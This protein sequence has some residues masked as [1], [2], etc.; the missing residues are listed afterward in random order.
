MTRTLASGAALAAA[1]ALV[2]AGCGGDSEPDVSA[3]TQWAGDLCAAVDT[4]QSSIASI[5]S[6]L[7]SDPTKDGLESA[8]SDAQDATETLID[9]VKGLGS[10]DTESGDQAKSTVESLADSLQTNVDTIEN[11]VEDV[12]GVQGL[13]TAVSTVSAAVA[14]MTSEL[15]SSV[16][17]LQ[18]LGNVDNELQQSFSEAESCNGVIPGS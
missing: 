11:A 4:W 14:K 9:T 16:T 15:S 13:L 1:L 12:S 10:P 18:S 5:A 6:T 2:A 8:A 17:E 7:T 3:S